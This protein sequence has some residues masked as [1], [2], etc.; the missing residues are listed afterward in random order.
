MD[1][2][3]LNLDDEIKNM[4]TKIIFKQNINLIKKISED[5]N[6]DLNILTRKYK[7]GKYD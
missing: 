3:Y 4:I 7:L 1:T 5:Y 2:N 6:R